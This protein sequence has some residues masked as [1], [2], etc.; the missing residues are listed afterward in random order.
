[1]SRLA[2]FLSRRP[3]VRPG[4]SLNTPPSSLLRSLAVSE[5]FT[6]HRFRLRRSRRENGKISMRWGFVCV[7]GEWEDWSNLNEDVPYWK[8]GSDSGDPRW[9]TGVSRLQCY[10]W[11]LGVRSKRGPVSKRPSTVPP[12]YTKEGWTPSTSPTLTSS[13]RTT[14][15]TR[16]NWVNSIQGNVGP[17][18]MGSGSL[19]LG[20]LCVTAAPTSFSLS[21]VISWT[22]L[23]VPSIKFQSVKE[24]Y[25]LR[26]SW[27]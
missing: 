23:K 17:D 26:L 7:C 20:N 15:G 14:R 11:D 24:P 6:S 19:P 9:N 13:D 4:P 3:S 5:S 22:T 21:V 18:S 2:P 16:I 25:S 1:M 12:S 27:K 10:P 8:K